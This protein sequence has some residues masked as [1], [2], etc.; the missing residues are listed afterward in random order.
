[1]FL[2]SS[3][4]MGDAK[5]TQP[6]A[7]EST[8]GKPVQLPCNHSEITGSEYIIWYRQIPHQGPEHVIESVRDNKTNG[9]A[10]LI[11]P[12]DRKSSTLILPQVTL[13]DAAVYYCIV[14]DPQCEG[15]GCTC[16]ISPWGGREAAAASKEASA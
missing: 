6:D 10:T 12:T 14:R 9:M 8:E 4:I 5:S 7:M 13:R 2:T 11:I 16:S 3:G 1:M 15:W